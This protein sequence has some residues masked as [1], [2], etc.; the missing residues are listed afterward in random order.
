MEIWPLT[1]LPAVIQK[2]YSFQLTQLVSI[3]YD[4]VTN[5][6]VRFIKHLVFEK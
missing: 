1:T 2:D 4:L 6:A 5:R 3:K